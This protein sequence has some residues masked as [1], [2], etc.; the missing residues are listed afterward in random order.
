MADTASDTDLRASHPGLVDTTANLA[1]GSSVP[2]GTVIRLW[3]DWRTAL[4]VDAVYANEA[5]AELCDTCGDRILNEDSKGIP[6]PTES[7]KGY[8]CPEC[9]RQGEG[10]CCQEHAG[11]DNYDPG[12]KR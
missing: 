11:D 1:D 6:L 3:V 5:D 4:W 12:D 9:T 8:H 2:T 10:L 7:C